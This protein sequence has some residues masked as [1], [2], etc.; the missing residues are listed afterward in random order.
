MENK[1]KITNVIKDLSPE[2]IVDIHN[3]Y[4]GRN[5]M[6][7]QYISRMG[8]LEDE[9]RNMYYDSNLVDLIRDVKN[10]HFELNDKFFYL[11]GYGHFQ[12]F[13]DPIYDTN[14]PIDMDAIADYV[15]DN[16]VNLDSDDIQSALDEINEELDED[17]DL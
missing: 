4:C 11:D 3:E 1:K 14:S 16:E 12:S 13:C 10:G 2:E 17:F 15:L 7:D 6:M 9:L 5:N 8:Y